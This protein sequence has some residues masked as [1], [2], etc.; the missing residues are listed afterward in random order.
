MV[1][2]FLVFSIFLTFAGFIM[3]IPDVSEIISSPYLNGSIHLA[4]AA[5]LVAGIIGIMCST[6]RED[7]NA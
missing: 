2:I 5:L 6:N 7:V 3:I 4:H 1:R